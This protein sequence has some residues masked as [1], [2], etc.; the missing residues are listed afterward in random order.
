MSMLPLTYQE[1]YSKRS[2]HDLIRV[3]GEWNSETEIRLNSHAG[4]GTIQVLDIEEGLQIRIWDCT[5]AT[6]L[7]IHRKTS[8][9]AS[10]KTFTLVYYMTPGSFVL[11]DCTSSGTINKLWNT[12]FMTSDAEFKV[13]ILQDMP[14]QCLSVNFT[15]IWLQ[16]NIFTDIDFQD[17]FF[18]QQVMKTKPFVMFESISHNE[19]LVIVNLFRNK[20]H[21]SFGKFFF[22]SKALNLLTEFFVR[23]KGRISA[24]QGS[25][26]YHEE[27]IAGAEKKL[28][29]NLNAGLPDTKRMA[30]DLSISE[31]T[32]KRYFKKTYGKNIYEYFLEQKMIHARK[33]LD[34]RKKSVTEI[35]YLLGYEKVSQFIHMFKRFYGIQPGA[36]KQTHDVPSLS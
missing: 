21:P 32:L 30:A 28:M 7:S 8:S 31:S 1:E 15:P 23:V 20:Y 33:L 29:E 9:N 18:Q 2:F 26:L 11:E 19:E 3:L 27:Q 6:E 24:Q 10:D 22:R 13:K 17:H 25:A 36:Y 35:A 34:E 16:K 14:M 12:V 5:L 4:I